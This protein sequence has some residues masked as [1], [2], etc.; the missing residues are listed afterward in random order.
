MGRAPGLGVEVE[1]VSERSGVLM[2]GGLVDSGLFRCFAACL[3]VDQGRSLRAFCITKERALRRPWR[4]HFADLDAS[5]KRKSCGADT[6]G[7]ET[8]C[9]P[10]AACLWFSIILL[11]RAP[12]RPGRV[13]GTRCSCPVSDEGRVVVEL[14]ETCPGRSRKV[15]NGKNFLIDAQSP[16]FLVSDR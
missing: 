2:V 12:G 13:G 9:F 15:Q 7:G 4:E 14:K 11:P 5:T 16:P 6:A 8:L 3:L 10:F 1:G